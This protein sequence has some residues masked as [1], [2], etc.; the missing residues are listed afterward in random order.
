M[1]EILNLDKMI[2]DD[3]QVILRGVTYKISGSLTVGMALGL[4]KK[5]GKFQENPQNMQAVQ[6]VI[7]SA[8]DIFKM[9]NPSMDIVKFQ[10]DLPVELIGEL[11]KFLVKT[12]TEVKEDEPEKKAEPEPVMM[13]S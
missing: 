3:K 4:F 2:P 1:V 5:F 10:N 6:E 11:V 9:A 8:V 12:A 7:E 13:E